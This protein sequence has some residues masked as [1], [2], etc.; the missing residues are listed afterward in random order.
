VAD[1]FRWSAVGRIAVTLAV[2][3]GCSGEDKGGCGEVPIN[4][5]SVGDSRTVVVRYV[6]ATVMDFTLDGAEWTSRTSVPPAPDG[7]SELTGTATLLDDW[8]TDLEGRMSL[9]FGDRGEVTF[10]GGPPACL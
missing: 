8:Q 5:M 3:V 10:T 9:D 6:T 7:T 2:L 1:C 4:S